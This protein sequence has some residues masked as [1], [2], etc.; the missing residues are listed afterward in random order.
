MNMTK[1]LKVLTTAAGGS[2]ANLI[3]EKLDKVLVE[4]ANRLVP[5]RAALRRVPWSTNAFECN[6]RTALP[7]SGFYAETAAFSETNSTYVRRQFPIKQLKAEGTVSNLLIDTSKDYINA[8]QVEIEGALRSL[9]Q[10]EEEGI[11]TGNETSVP[12]QFDGLRVQ[13]TSTIDAAG[14]EISL[15]LLDQAIRAIREQGAV[16][17]LIVCS[18]REYMRLS[19]IMRGSTTY[20]WT[21]V[22]TEFGVDLIKY[23]NIPI[24]ASHYM[25]TNL[26]Y[27]TTPATTFSEVLVLDTTQILIP[28]VRDITYEEVPETTDGISFRLKTYMGCAVKYPLAQRRITNLAAPTTI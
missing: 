25:P 8:L 24:I 9:V 11:I 18:I 28:V 15:N 4:E 22:A 7:T 23:M 10:Y 1:I 19:Q 17:N 3:I 27:G 20:N 16:P 6:V 5:L 21:S 12:A 2:G 26:T 13:I 14:V